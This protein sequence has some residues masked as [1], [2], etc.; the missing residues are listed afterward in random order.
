[1]KYCPNCGTENLD[2]NRVCSQCQTPFNSPEL[3]EQFT[4]AKQKAPSNKRKILTPILITLGII[5]IFI[6][7]TSTHIICINHSWRTPTCI[8]PAQCYYCDKYK[9]DN[10]GNHDW[11]EATCTSPKTC[12]W[13]NLEEGEPLGH[14]WGA[15]SCTNPATCKNCGEVSEEA[16][17]HTEGE[18]T[19]TQEATFDE[20]GT[21]SLLCSVCNEPIDSRSIDKK[22]PAV[23]GESF[24]FTDYELI[25]WLNDIAIFDIGYTNVDDSSDKNTMYLISYESEIGGLI[26]NHGEND[27]EGNVR[28]IMVYFEDWT[29]SVVIAAWIGEQIDADFSGDDSFVDI[30]SGNPYTAA[31]MTLVDV[32]DVIA[33]TPSENLA[34]ILE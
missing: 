19:I 25:S 29:T 33:L 34:R 23:I 9:D 20:D 27:K 18:W 14:N 15:G 16:I 7:L 26:L 24:N 22:V 5:I 17:G 6:F 8:E 31:N 11:T 30:A 13:C 3:Q 10:L 1:M 21:E 12:F 2:E 28:A 4:D 32:D